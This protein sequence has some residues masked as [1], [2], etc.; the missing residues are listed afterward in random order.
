[1]PQT[2]VPCAEQRTDPHVQGAR[3]DEVLAPMAVILDE[4]RQQ[5]R[6]RKQQ[7]RRVRRE[8]QRATVERLELRQRGQRRH[9]GGDAVVVAV[10]EELLGD[11]PV[12]DRPA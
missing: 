12:L 8:E 1:M 6:Q 4:E 3:E 2:L 11:G 7:L 10:G 5:L 9:E